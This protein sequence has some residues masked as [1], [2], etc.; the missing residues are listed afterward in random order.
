MFLNAALAQNE[1]QVHTALQEALQI[2]LGFSAIAVTA[3]F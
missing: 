1:T 2:Q 3:T